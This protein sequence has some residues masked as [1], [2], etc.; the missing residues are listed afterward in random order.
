MFLFT[1]YFHFHFD[2]T[3]IIY[4]YMFLFK[5]TY[6]LEGNTMTGDGCNVQSAVCFPQ[7]CGCHLLPKPERCL[8]RIIGEHAGMKRS[9]QFISW[10]YEEYLFL[11]MGIV[12]NFFRKCVHNILFFIY[13]CCLNTFYRWMRTFWVSTSC[14]WKSKMD[15]T[16]NHTVHNICC[17]LA[18]N[19]YSLLF[20][21]QKIIFWYESL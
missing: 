6:L 10:K 14:H 15:L 8:R 7:L 21:K 4:F 1:T 9:G 20:D 2:L 19:T 17:C 16:Y 18:S 11:S 5:S 3:E 12:F 13:I